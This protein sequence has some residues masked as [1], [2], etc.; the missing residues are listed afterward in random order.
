MGNLSLLAATLLVVIVYFSWTSNRAKILHPQPVFASEEAVV[1]LTFGHRLKPPEVLGQSI[2]AVDAR[3]AIVDTF[4]SKYKSPMTGLGHYMVDTAEKYDLPFGL[5]PAISGCES[6]WGKVIPHE[7][8]NA[9][10]Y[11]VYG[12]SVMRFTSWEEAIDRVAKGLR[13]DYFDRGLTTP[14]RIMT[15]YTPSSNGS[16]AFCVG[17]FLGELQ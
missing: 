3:A 12:K 5:I 15:R 14:E 17:K 6:N 4:L 7:S 11:G 1:G 10:G 8:F 13:Q 2:T 9:W 16:W